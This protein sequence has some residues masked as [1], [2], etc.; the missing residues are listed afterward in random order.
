MSSFIKLD[1]AIARWEWYK[2]PSTFKVFLHCLISANW[3]RKQWQGFTIKRG[4]FVSSVGALCSETGLTIQQVR[5]SLKR[6]QRTGEITLNSTNK[7]T[8]I[9]VEKYNSYQDKMPIA[10]KQTTNE[11]QTNNNQLTTTKEL[12]EIKELKELEEI[13][14]EV[15]KK[16]PCKSLEEA[17]RRLKNLD[18][19]DLNKFCKKRNFSD[20]ELILSEFEVYIQKKENWKK[21]KDFS[22][23]VKSW[24][25]REIRK[26]NKQLEKGYY[27]KGSEGFNKN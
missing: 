20:L 16:Q 4:Q 24:I 13:K 18:L 9:T 10:N 15:E 1:R 2:E 8:F 11:Q 23:A 21:Y 12:E 26:G 25:N 27:D 14:E 5:T 19:D 17:K 22:L 6:L 3:E 7:F